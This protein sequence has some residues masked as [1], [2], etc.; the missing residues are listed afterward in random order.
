[1]PFPP[2]TK[3]SSFDYELAL[4]QHVPIPPSFF[5]RLEADA[6][7]MQRTLEASLAAVQD[8]TE[9]LRLEIAKEEA[10]LASERRSLQDMDKNAKRAEAERKRQMKNV[11]RTRIWRGLY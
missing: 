8:S 10:F 5:P 6:D 7:E 2:N 3:D 11:C 9:L 4:D 1:M